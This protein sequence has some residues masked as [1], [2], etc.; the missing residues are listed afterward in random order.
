MEL[1]Q[2]LIAILGLEGGATEDQLVM[3]F[4][5]LV[6]AAKKIQEA[7]EAKWDAEDAARAALPNEMPMDE[8]IGKVLVLVDDGAVALANEK[9]ARTQIEESLTVEK[10]ARTAAEESFTAERKERV[11]LLVNEAVSSGKILPADKDTWLKDLGEDFA[12]KSLAL[13]LRQ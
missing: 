4:T 5:K 3:A 1:L 9:T 7:V 10:A 2:R 12:K 6:E 13:A 11:V 8:A